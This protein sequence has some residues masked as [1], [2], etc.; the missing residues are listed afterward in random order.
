MA[1]STIVKMSSINNLSDARYCAGMGVDLMGFCIDP[2]KPDFLTPLQ[3]KEITGWLAGVKMV[4]ETGNVPLT[5]IKETL[6]DYRFDYIEVGN[7][8]E[9][10]ALSE[11]G[12]H[13]IYKVE[14]IHHLPSLPEHSDIH[15]YLLKG[16]EL[17]SNALKALKEFSKKHSVILGFGINKKNVKDLLSKTHIKGIELKG[18]SEISPGLRDFDDLADILEILEMEE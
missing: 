13:F 11:F 17:D 1:L 6:K 12:K 3:F 5:E 2:S 8:E 4:A 18:G 14:D 9:M 16:K 7:K 10:E 15:Y